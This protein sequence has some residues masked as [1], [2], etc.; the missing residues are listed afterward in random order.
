MST[1]FKSP[2]ILRGG[3]I[4]IRLVGLLRAIMALFYSSATKQGVRLAFTIP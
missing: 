3:D 4:P 2:T 1:P